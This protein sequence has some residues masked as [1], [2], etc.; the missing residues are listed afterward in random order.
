METIEI[1]RVIERRRR[2]LSMPARYSSSTKFVAL[3]E[4]EEIH[5][6][7]GGRYNTYN[8]FIEAIQKR[9]G[10][11]CQYNIDRRRPYVHYV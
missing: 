11:G 7:C 5:A 8:Q 10:D 6:Y 9:F 3:T 4:R 1:H 2:K